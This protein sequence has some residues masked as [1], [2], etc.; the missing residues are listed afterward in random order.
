MKIW[1]VK[2]QISREVALI[3]YKR[4]E[5]ID[6]SVFFQGERLS[7]SW[8]VPAAQQNP[9]QPGARAVDFP[10]F[11]YGALLC[12]ASAWKVLEA[13]LA[14]E[15]ELLPVDVEG[16]DYQLLN[17]IQTIDCLNKEQSIVTY[18]K[19]GRVTDIDHYVINEEKFDGVYIFKMPEL[20]RT[21]IY[22]TEAFRDL[23]TR[24]GLEGL[25]FLDL[26]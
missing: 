5:D 12:S 25:E 24:H 18:Y 22:A 13:H 23:V 16:F 21:H 14:S 20:R 3:A 19:T 15:V 7:E 2:N 1:R 17:P 26:P 4:F 9:S 10:F 6:P 11:E 8:K